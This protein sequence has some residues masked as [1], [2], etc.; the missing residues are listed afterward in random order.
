MV[1][2][3]DMEKNRNSVVY[4]NTQDSHERLV[5]EAVEETEP[6]GSV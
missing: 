1:S 4:A 5:R 3:D 2:L 6:F